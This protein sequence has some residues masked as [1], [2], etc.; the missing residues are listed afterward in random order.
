MLMNNTKNWDKYLI[1]HFGIDKPGYRKR[2]II[3]LKEGNIKKL[4]LPLSF[5]YIN[6]IDLGICQ[7]SGLFKLKYSQKAHLTFIS[8]SEW[9]RSLRLERFLVKFEESGYD[10]Y[11]NLVFQMSTSNCLTDQSLREE[12]GIEERK[13]R[14][15]I[16]SQL[17][18]GRKKKLL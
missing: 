12:V 7:R 13:A 3:K 15:K 11:E 14:E 1:S 17:N 8:I 2:I 9:L 6:P 18:E 4:S 10:D 16:L 5:I